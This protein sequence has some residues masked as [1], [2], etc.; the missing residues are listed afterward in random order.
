MGSFWMLVQR[1]E[2]IADPRILRSGLLYSDCFYGVIFI[3]V[4]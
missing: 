4:D 1:K 2:Y 3:G